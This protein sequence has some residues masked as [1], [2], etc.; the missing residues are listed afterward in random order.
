MANGFNNVPPVLQNVVDNALGGNIGGIISTRPIA[1][2]MSGARCVLKINDKVAAFAFAISWRVQTNYREVNTIDNILPEEMMPQSIKVDGSISALH[3]PG[4]GPGTQLWQPDVLSFL[5]HQY[6][7]IE[8]RDSQTDQ[9][10][11]YAPRAVITTRQE[12]LRVDQLA[13]VS[14]NFMAIGFRDEKDPSYPQDFDRA[15]AEANK[16]VKNGEA[17][18]VLK[19]IA[20]A[21]AGIAGAATSS[22]KKLI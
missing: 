12:E 13:N 10:L 1:K 15:S 7:K 11:F 4:Q 9:L 17:T 5:F 16:S 21:A 6:I 22:L 18:N 14:L 3:I 8:V 20:D 2:Y 19:S